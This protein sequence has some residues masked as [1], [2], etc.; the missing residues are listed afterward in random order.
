MKTISIALTAILISANMLGQ[1]KM[2]Q[3]STT[4]T[5]KQD[6]GMG[7]VELTYS[8][9]NLKGR[10]VIG[11][12]DPWDKVWR[13]GA[14]AATKIK[15]TDEVSIGGKKIDTGTYVIYAIPHKN[16]DWD[17][18]I[19]KGV[20]NWGA[21]GYTEADDVVRLKAPAVKNKKQKVE[22]FTMQFGNIMYESMDIQFMWNDWAVSFPVTT[23]IKDRL[24]AQ[25]ET[26]LQGEKKPYQQ[27]ANFYYEWDKDYAKALENV[28][29]A[30]DANAK[31]FWLYLLKAKILKDQ[32][33]NADAK[34]AAQ[35]CVELAT[36]AKNDAYITQGNDLIKKL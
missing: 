11:E 7:S 8:R 21:D 14:N 31:G 9:P 24:R 1:V 25:I 23:N 18:I 33:N 19:N 20:K 6:F 34:V 17:I 35:K 4:Q 29:K 15:F 26:A 27:A 13:M 3:A 22:T 2:P 10:K 28:N 32:G 12:Q 36:A 5:I 30:I 16:E